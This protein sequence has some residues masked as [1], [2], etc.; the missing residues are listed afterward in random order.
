MTVGTRHTF[1]VFK[2][3]PHEIIYVGILEPL[4]HIVHWGY[5]HYVDFSW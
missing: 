4:S 2:K 5:V 1:H 3:I